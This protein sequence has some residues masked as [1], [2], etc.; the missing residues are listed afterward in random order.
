MTPRSVRSEGSLSVSTLEMPCH[1]GTQ[2]MEPELFPKW[3][4][5][6]TAA[7]RLFSTFIVTY[8]GI[9]DWE[10]VQGI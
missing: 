4:L 10:E 9:L 5:L 1:S 3:G 7:I 6:G 2:D 8:P